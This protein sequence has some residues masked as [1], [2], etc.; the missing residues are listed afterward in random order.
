MTTIPEQDRLRLEQLGDALH[1][2]ASADLAGA[3]VAPRPSR[4]RVFV[5]AAVAALIA[6]PGVAFA[7][8]ALIGADEVARSIPNGT[9]ALLGTNPTCT[10]VREG[11]EFDCTLGRA[12]TGEIQPGAWKGTVE[13]TVDD[14]KRVNGGCRSLA[15]D[16]THWRCYVGREAVRQQIIGPD[17]LGQ[18]SPGP[19]VG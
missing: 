5:A 12:P 7:A 11:I 8:N 16:G 3:R 19:G 15:A 4:R 1:A 18:T 17:F 10:T 9:L 13:P 14:A 6:V 2:A